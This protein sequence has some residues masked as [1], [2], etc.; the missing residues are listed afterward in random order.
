M[1]TWLWRPWLVAVVVGWD[2]VGRIQQGDEQRRTRHLAIDAHPA[3]AW[4]TDWYTTAQFG[5]LYRGTGLL[6]DMGRPVTI[7]AAQMTLSSGH[8]ARLQLRVGI[9]PA[10]A[11]L[12]SVAHAANAGGV[13]RLRLEGRT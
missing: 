13:L 8:G 9:A 2:L 7:T 4:R 12:P 3:T 11:D 1:G 10:L 5:S 6:L